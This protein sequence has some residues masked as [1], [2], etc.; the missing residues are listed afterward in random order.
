MD[1][2]DAIKAATKSRDKFYAFVD[3]MPITDA[4]KKKMKRMAG[5]FVAA[6]RTANLIA[7]K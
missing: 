4:D 2:I 6:V 5:D 7:S 3:S 1:A